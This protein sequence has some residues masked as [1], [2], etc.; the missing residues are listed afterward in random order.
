MKKM[1][2]GFVAVLAIMV[3]ATTTFTNPASAT[4]ILSFTSDVGSYVGK[5]ENLSFDSEE[6][7]VFSYSSNNWPSQ[8]FIMG[9]SFADGWQLTIGAPLGQALAVGHY[10]DAEWFATQAL[11]GLQLL[12]YNG[13]G[14]S[15]VRSNF[16]VLE[17]AYDT[18]PWTMPT[19]TRLAVNFS[20]F[21]GPDYKLGLYGQFRL[22]SNVP[23]STPEPSTFILLFAGI[24][25]LALLRLRR[26]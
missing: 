11:P 22:N 13:R 7:T 10:S 14:T 17:V 15:N 5:G 6:Y 20:Q 26:K 1:S 4:T 16:D 23:I 19:I 9:P 3:M 8:F 25:G 21:E 2:H 24:S 12:G 18:S